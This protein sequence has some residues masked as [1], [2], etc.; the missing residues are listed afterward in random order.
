[1]PVYVEALHLHFIYC[2]KQIT[3][4]FW[5]LTQRPKVGLK[6]LW[7]VETPD[8]RGVGRGNAVLPFNTRPWHLFYQIG[9][10]KSSEL[11]LV[12]LPRFVARQL[13]RNEDH[14]CPALGNKPSMG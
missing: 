13:R 3:V 10:C 8:P 11:P 1:M 2:I 14:G 9:E 5:H 12:P 6:E 4:K 7:T